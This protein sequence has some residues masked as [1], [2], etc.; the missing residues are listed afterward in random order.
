[1]GLVH[2]R[3]VGEEA[4]GA[5]QRPGQRL[6]EAEV[7]RVARPGSSAP[8]C[9]PTLAKVVL[10]LLAK[11]LVKSCVAVDLVAVVV[12]H[13]AA[14]RHAARVVELGVWASTAPVCSAGRRH[15]DL[16]DRA[17]RIEALDGAVEERPVR[18]GVEVLPAAR[19]A[20]WGRSAD[21]RP[22]PGWRRCAGSRATTAPLRFP[23]ASRGRPL[24]RHVDGQ[25]EIGAAMGLAEDLVP[26][27]W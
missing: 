2:A 13:V 14:R 24:H 16:E 1:M 5:A 3:R 11:A 18:V 21:R 17:R 20:C 15:D 6:A 8:S 4:G 9:T 10:M 12:H 22:W 27:S 19:R 7:G 25:L 26:G 23:S